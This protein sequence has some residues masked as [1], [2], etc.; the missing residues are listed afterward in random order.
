M[1]RFNAHIEANRQRYFDEL[2]SLLRQPSIAAQGIGIEE[3]AGLVVSRCQERGTMSP[4]HRFEMSPVHHT[5][6]R[7]TT[8]S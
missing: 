1:E 8:L 4:N 7:L 3:T 2:Y 5:A 6:C